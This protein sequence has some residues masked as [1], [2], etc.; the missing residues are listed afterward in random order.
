MHSPCNS[1]NCEHSALLIHI[2]NYLTNVGLTLWLPCS[3]MAK[4][5]YILLSTES[6]GLN[7]VGE[8]RNKFSKY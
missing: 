2:H 4:V 7:T 8:P 3:M 5:L 1:L 6:L